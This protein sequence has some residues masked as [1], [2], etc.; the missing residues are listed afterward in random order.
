MVTENHGVRQVATN[1]H[2]PHRDTHDPADRAN[3]KTSTHYLLMEDTIFL[4]IQPPPLL[5]FLC[6]SHS[7]RTPLATVAV[8]MCCRQWP[9]HVHCLGNERRG[10]TR[11]A[12]I[13][14]CV[15]PSLPSSARCSRACRPMLMPR[16]SSSAG[17]N[18]PSPSLPPSLRTRLPLFFFSGLRGRSCHLKKSYK[19]KQ[20]PPPI[21]VSLS[22]ASF[23]FIGIAFLL[24][25]SQ[26]THLPV[27]VSAI[28]DTNMEWRHESF[29][30][31]CPFAN[32]GL[33]TVAHWPFFNTK[34]KINKK[35]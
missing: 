33:L 25:Q 31:T 28:W 18:H 35:H 19:I 30:I 3:V 34:N 8:T 2:Q 15:R 6:H 26:Q 10:G 11:S 14:P 1:A 29:L 32:F 22:L 23:S 13:R 24:L 17:L 7:A 27:W 4:S 16:V 21:S 5:L 20:T 12:S 9:Q